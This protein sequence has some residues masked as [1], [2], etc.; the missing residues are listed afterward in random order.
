MIDFTGLNGAQ[1]HAM[2]VIADMI[3]NTRL[4]AQSIVALKALAATLEAGGRAFSV[5][6]LRQPRA[7][8]S[9]KR[10]LDDE[11]DTKLETKIAFSFDAHL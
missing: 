10:P 4:D 3:R 7:A 2:S 6:L 8:T 1:I 11:A 5:T 9:G